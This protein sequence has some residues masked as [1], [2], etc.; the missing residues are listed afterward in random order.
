MIW[1]RALS[2]VEVNEIMKGNFMVVS[3]KEKIALRWGYIKAN[4]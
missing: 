2:E 3:L 1:N 4:F